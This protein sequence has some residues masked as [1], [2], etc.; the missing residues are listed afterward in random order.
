MP[1]GLVV[2]HARPLR[3]V[4][5]DGIAVAFFG[6]GKAIRRRGRGR[7]HSIIRLPIGEVSRL[8]N[9]ATHEPGRVPEEVRVVIR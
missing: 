8:L 6:G 5:A 3:D 7:T 4:A 2:C 9:A 1:R